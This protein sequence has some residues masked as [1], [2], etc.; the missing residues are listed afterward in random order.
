LQM[1]MLAHELPSVRQ[2]IG[3]GARI[4]SS[5]GSLTLFER[6]DDGALEPTLRCGT[7][8]G[9]SALLVEKVLAEGA[10]KTGGTMST[11]DPG[12]NER[13]RGRSDEYMASGR[14]CLVRPLRAYGE[15][16]GALVLHYDDRI[17]LDDTEFDTL[18]RFAEFAA[19]VLSGARTRAD[20]NGYAYNDPLTG[21]GNRRRLTAE[22]ARLAGSRLALL[23][24]DFDGLKLVNDKLT[25]EDG[26]HLIATIGRVLNT[27]ARPDELVV[28]YGGDEF[29]VMIEG[30]GAA[31]SR[32][33]ADEITAV[34]DRITLPPA[35]SALFRGAS[36]G[37]ATVEPNE[38]AATALA[39]AAAE[40]RS[41]KRRRKTDREL[42]GAAP[43]RII[44]P[45][46]DVA[47]S[48]GRQAG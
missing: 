41:R 3:R 33:R 45:S 40:M 37:W 39:R 34:I 17:V 8:L 16:V 48:Q 10:V 26:D 5:Y 44:S 21:L 22:F 2:T 18:R 28:R 1:L 6:S 27:L 19:A 14:L 29:V 9:P 25:Y 42:G 4:L 36:V 38:S 23:L 11:I 15:V 32:E 30:A 20:L 31:Y 13:E 46:T 24:V 43:E 7:A 12:D 47:E 35:T